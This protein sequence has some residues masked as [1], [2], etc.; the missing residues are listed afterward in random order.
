MDINIYIYGY[1]I[2]AHFKVYGGM[3]GLG[4]EAS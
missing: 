3:S 1:L 4:L 2:L